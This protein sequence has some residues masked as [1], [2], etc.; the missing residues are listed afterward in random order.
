MI[1]KDGGRGYTGFM[2]QTWDEPIANKQVLED[3]EIDD[4]QEMPIFVAFM[5]DGSDN[6][7]AVMMPIRGNDVDMTYYSIREIVKVISD[8]EDAMLPKYKGTVNV[9][10]EV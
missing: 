5:W 1:V 9:F 6:L 3:F 8:T 4:T 2:V 10:R 7:N